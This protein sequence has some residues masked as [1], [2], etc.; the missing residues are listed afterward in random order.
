[1]ASRKRRT[2]RLTIEYDAHAV[3]VQAAEIVPYTPVLRDSKPGVGSD[4]LWVGLEGAGRRFARRLPDPA[5]GREIFAPD[6]AIARLEPTAARTISVDVPWHDEAPGEVVIR[7]PGLE[8]RTP[9]IE[10]ARRAAAVARTAPPFPVVPL[11]GLENPNAL[12]LVFLAEGFRADELPLYRAVV[13]AFLAKLAATPPFSEAMDTLCAL[14]MDSV[15]R[16]SGLDDP[17]AGTRADTLL[18][19]SFGDPNNPDPNKRTPHRLITVAASEADD[20]AARAVSGGRAFV[21][22][23]VVNTDEYGGSGGK[24]AVFSRDSRASDIALHELGHT[25]FGLADE[26]SDAG[27]S[28]SPSE[29]NVSKKPS[30]GSGPWS[31]TDRQRLKWRA[32]LTPG[33]ALP[34]SSNPDCGQAHVVTGPAGVGAFEGGKYKHC[35]VFRPTADC[36]MR[37][38]TAGFC[39]VCQDVIRRKLA[40]FRRP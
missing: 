24:V 40:T 8:V 37:T 32:F 10:I 18:D 12:A 23:V 36:K 20:L 39:P 16:E 19:A 1:M 22:I 25:L 15:S 13:D 14:R 21:G 26:Y 34:T 30:G 38:L 9:A 31:D 6:G 2:L 27:T 29:P 33:L 28:G 11:F 17:E 35:K 7:G 3:R 4:A 5:V